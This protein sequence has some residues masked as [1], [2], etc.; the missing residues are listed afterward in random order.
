MLNDGKSQYAI[1]EPICK[2]QTAVNYMIDRMRMI[3]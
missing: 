2:P 3:L 1:A